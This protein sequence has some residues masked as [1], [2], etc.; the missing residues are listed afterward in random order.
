MTT[1][2]YP[3]M[4]GG[5]IVAKQQLETVGFTIDLQVIDWATVVERRAK[6][7]EWDVFMTSHGFVPDPSQISYV[8]QMNSTPVGGADEDSLALASELSAESEFESA[9]RSGTRSRPTPTPKSRRSR[10]VTPAPS[11]TT[12]TTSAVGPTRSNA[13]FMYWN[14]WLQV[15]LAGSR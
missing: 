2:E 13:A 11:P 1:Q 4:Y 3:Y 7:E 15:A 9:S 14:L 5:A 8:G 6:P 10:S 12:G